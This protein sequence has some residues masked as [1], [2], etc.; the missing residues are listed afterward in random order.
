[1]PDVAFIVSSGFQMM[2]FAGVSV[3]EMANISAG[4]KLYDLRVLSETGGAVSSSVGVAIDTEAFS[5]PAF[6]TLII[7]GM[8]QPVP[9]TIGLINF[10]RGALPSCR[11]VASVCTGAFVLGEAGLLDGRRVTTHWAFAR[12]LQSRFPRAKV[13]PD[14]IFIDESPVW[15]SA[16]MAAGIE[17]ILGMVE[18][19]YGP[20]LTRLTAQNLVVDHRRPGGQPQRSV[21][22]EIAPTSDRIQIALDHARRNLHMSL[23][24]ERLADVANLSP[25]QFSRAFR[26]ETGETPARA[27]ERLRLETARLMLGE[28][29]HRIEDVAIETGFGDP[30]RMRRAFLRAFGQPPQAFRRE[31]RRSL[32]AAHSS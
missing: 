3:F 12:E 15:T 25:R 10:V 31:A 29:R 18:R 14:R 1:M 5:D 28:S 26:A 13:E 24:V 4:K 9:S 23:T 19:D 2:V 30:E 8:V 11:R 7:A 22:L 6:D 17:L 16:G 32:T 27:V 21:L 20:E